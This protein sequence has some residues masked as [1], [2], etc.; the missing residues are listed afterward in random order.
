[1]PLADVVAVRDARPRVRAAYTVVPHLPERW[2]NACSSCYKLGR[3]KSAW[4]Q[5]I[6]GVVGSPCNDL[7][8]TGYKQVFAFSENQ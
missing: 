2:P 8:P 4:L 7:K 6:N 1:M 5:G 3:E